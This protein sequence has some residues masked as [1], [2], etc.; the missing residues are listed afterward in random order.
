MISTIM[1][2][3]VVLGMNKNQLRRSIGNPDLSIRHQVVM[4]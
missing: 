1:R 3:E 4:D 2:N